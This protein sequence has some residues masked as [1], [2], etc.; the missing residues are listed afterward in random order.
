MTI[1]KVVDGDKITISP[2]G[3]LDTANAPAFEAA[4]EEVLQSTSNLTVDFAKVE[5]ISSSGLRV[6]LKVQKKI[7]ATGEMTL[8]NVNQ[9]VNEVFELTGFNSILNIV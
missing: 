7:G 2:E 9:S 8:I 1:N 6:L 4:M 5:Y 3:M